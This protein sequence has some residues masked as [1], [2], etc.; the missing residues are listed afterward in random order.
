M[1]FKSLEMRNGLLVFPK[2]RCLV[3]K[4]LQLSSSRVHVCESRGKRLKSILQAAVTVT[5]FGKQKH[6]I[7]TETSQNSGIFLT[8][9][10]CQSHGQKS[11]CI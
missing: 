7:I 4:N 9:G 10:T 6:Y 8:D 1:V 3:F 5:L 2:G 11:H